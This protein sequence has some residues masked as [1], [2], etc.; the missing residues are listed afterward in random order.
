MEAANIEIESVTGFQFVISSLDASLLSNILYWLDGFDIAMLWYSGDLKLRYL[1]SEGRAVT[2]FATNFESRYRP[3]PVAYPRIVDSFLGLKSLELRSSP[4]FT[5]CIPSFSPFEYLESLVLDIPSCT[6]FMDLLSSNTNPFPNLRKLSMLGLLEKWSEEQLQLLPQTLE[7][8]EIGPLPTVADISFLP[9]SL[10][11]LVIYCTM[12]LYDGVIKFPPHLSKLIIQLDFLDWVSTAKPFIASLPSGMTWLEMGG[13]INTLDFMSDL[14]PLLTRLHFSIS[15]PVLSASELAPLQKLV[16]LLTH[17]HVQFGSSAPLSVLNVLSPNLKH[18]DFSGLEP[19]PEVELSFPANALSV[20][21]PKHGGYISSQSQL[22]SIIGSLPRT[23]TSALLFNVSASLWTEGAIASLPR[24]LEILSLA[25]KDASLMQYLPSNL[26]QLVLGGPSPDSL[27]ILEDALLHLPV[28]L[29]DLSLSYLTPP[30]LRIGWAGHLKRLRKVLFTHVKSNVE[31][32]DLRALVSPSLAMLSLFGTEKPQNITFPGKEAWIAAMCHLKVLNELEIRGLF[33][34]PD[35]LY[36][37]K[38]RDVL[39]PIRVLSLE[40]IPAE[41][42]LTDQHIEATNLKL[43]TNLQLTGA[44]V[45]TDECL[46]LLPIQPLSIQ[47]APSSHITLHAVS[48][49]V[50]SRE[51]AYQSVW[52]KN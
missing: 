23:L 17:L 39:T 38:K 45:C 47:I 25:I 6:G 18:I 2:R 34:D 3:L 30:P 35:I 4:Y 46:D 10:T 28:S 29:T 52:L 40:G 49:I 26:T 33:S 1:M 13:Y 16:P 21:L 7:T 36:G 15:S 50:Q 32:D 48:K 11:S 8:L 14:P 22:L 44:S 9:S 51:G 20:P 43:C 27:P 19:D 5:T 37:L 31:P 42:P 12:A 24:P 41:H